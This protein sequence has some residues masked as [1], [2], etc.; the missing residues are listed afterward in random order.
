M[1]ILNN[2]MSAKN[3]QTDES[4]LNDM[5]AGSKAAAAAYLNATLESATPELK[6]IYT[7]SLGQIL[8]AHASATAVAVDHRWYKPY[9]SPEQQLADEYKKSVSQIEY[10]K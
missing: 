7:N 6:S 8:Q 1:D 5:L 2:F 9:E 10:N 4:L 3:V